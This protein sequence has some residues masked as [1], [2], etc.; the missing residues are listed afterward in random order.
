MVDNYDISLHYDNQIMIL[1][2]LLQIYSGVPT[3]LPCD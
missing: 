1:K 3:E 2:V